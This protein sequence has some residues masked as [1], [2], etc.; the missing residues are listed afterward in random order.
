MVEKSPY[1]HYI[2]DMTRFGADLSLFLQS[3]NYSA[4]Y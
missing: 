1:G 3:M 2:D 4:V